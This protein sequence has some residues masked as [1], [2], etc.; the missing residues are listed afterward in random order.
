MSEQVTSGQLIKM[1]RLSDPGGQ[2]VVCFEQEAGV[3]EVWKGGDE[4]VA[5]MRFPTAKPAEPFIECLS[6]PWPSQCAELRQ[7][8]AGGGCPH[9]SKAAT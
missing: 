7:C 2:G 5:I 3:L 4:Y 6:C 1:L 8:E 9:D